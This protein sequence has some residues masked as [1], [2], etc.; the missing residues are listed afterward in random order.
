MSISLGAAIVVELENGSACVTGEDDEWGCGIY[1]NQ[2]QSRCQM[3]A[4][5]GTVG[6]CSEY[7]VSR[8]AKM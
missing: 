4:G 7:P 2:L 3:R 6:L 5:S 8:R 1:N